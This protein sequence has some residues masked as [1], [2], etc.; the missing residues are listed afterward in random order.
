MTMMNSD[1]HPLGRRCSQLALT[2]AVALA[3]QSALAVNDLPGGPAVN[4]LNLHPAVTKIADEQHSLHYMMLGICTVIFIAVFSV[5]F[6]S[7]YKHRKSKGA[8][9]AD[10]HE[11]TRHHHSHIVPTIQPGCLI[12]HVGLPE[13]FLMVGE[14]EFEPISMRALS[15]KYL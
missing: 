9:P 6:Y 14:I 12:K 8:K 11:S 5:M 4:Q 7:I 10:F 13:V 3:S 15:I 2:A 1:V